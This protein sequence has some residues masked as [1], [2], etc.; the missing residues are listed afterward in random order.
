MCRGS[1]RCAAG[2]SAAPNRTPALCRAAA[3]AAQST[4][5]P[6]VAAR[7]PSPSP[8]APAPASSNGAGAGASALTFQEAVARLQQYWA[9][10][11]CAVWVPHNSEA[12]HMLPQSTQGS[13]STAGRK[14]G[15]CL[16]VHTPDA[17]RQGRPCMHACHILAGPTSGKVAPHASCLLRAQWPYLSL[18]S[19]VL[20]DRT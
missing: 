16:V 13:T 8:P 19:H 15:V 1:C 17:L 5:G 4:A 12:R 9:A 14:I 20:L 2:A 10:Q 6:A 18:S 3:G 11:G 7:D